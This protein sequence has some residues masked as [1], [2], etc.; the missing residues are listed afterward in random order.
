MA[1]IIVCDDKY[2]KNVY[3]HHCREGNQIK[4]NYFFE[5][6]IGKPVC[7]YVVCTFVCWYN[8]LNT[9]FLIILII[10][11]IFSFFFLYNRQQI[12]Y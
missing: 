2:M 3:N 11:N 7:M 6:M 4:S 12:T 9:F 10:D 8:L 5:W 1:G